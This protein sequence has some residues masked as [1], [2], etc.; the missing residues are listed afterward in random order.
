MTLSTK[1]RESIKT[2]L[3]MTIAY[4]IALSMGWDK[5]KWAGIALIFVSLSKSCLLYTSDA[6]D[7]LQPVKK[8]L[9][10]VSL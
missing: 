9:F 4:G 3:A 6:A 1:T 2:A 5:T 7:D 10:Y 8:S